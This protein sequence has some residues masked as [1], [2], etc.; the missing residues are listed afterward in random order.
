LLGLFGKFG[1]L[2]AAI[3]QPVVGGLYCTLF[4]L[5]A[6]VGVRQ[7]AKADLNSDRN[8]LIGGFSLFMGLS[9]PF[10]FGPHST[11]QADLTWMPAGIRAVVIALGST[12]MAVAALLGI[13]LDNLIPGT[14]K[15]RGLIESPG[16]L[17]PEAG[18]VDVVG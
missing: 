2:A 17:V 12:G 8:L 15:E 10:Y 14:K 7:F 9:V 16:I 5:I 18:D 6:A 3:P 1:A 11:G 4:G 13:V